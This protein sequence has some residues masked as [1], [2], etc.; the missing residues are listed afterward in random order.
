MI[1]GVSGKKQHGKDTFYFAVKN[2]FTDYVVKRYGFADKVKEFAQLYFGIPIELW[3]N[4]W[5]KEQNRYILQ[6]IGNMLRE[7]NDYNFWV[8]K[9]ISEIQK[10]THTKTIHIITDV[11]Y[12]NEADIMSNHNLV[13]VTDP[14]KKSTDTHISETDL[15]DYTFN[16][17]ILNDGSKAD[18]EGKV[19]QWVTNKLKSENH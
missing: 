13:R 1:I 5:F 6:G 2:H 9:V 15:D 4:L 3:N 17:I 7:E 14:R 18:Y 19:I 10:D 16:D 8:N 11:R 12:K